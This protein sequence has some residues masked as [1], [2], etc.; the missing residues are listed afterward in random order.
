MPVASSTT[1]V[2]TATKSI[3]T[4][5]IKLAPLLG[6]FFRMALELT[7][8]KTRSATAPYTLLTLMCLAVLTVPVRGQNNSSAVRGLLTGY[9][10]VAY[11]ALPGDHFQNDFT[12]NFAPTLLFQVH[13]DILFDGEMDFELE[14]GGTEVHLEHAQI[15]Y[16]GFEHLQFS[17][18][19]FHLPF[20]TW[21][22]ASWIN[23]MPTPPL[24]YEDS[25]GAPPENALLPLPFD[26]GVTARVTLPLIDGWR[27]SAALWVSQ[28]PASGVPSH[29]HGEE[30]P[31][32][33]PASDAPP[34]SY[35]ANFEDNN[36]DKMV[37]LRLRAVSGGGL[38]LQGSGFR[39]AYDEAGD[40]SVYGLNLSLIWTPGSVPQPLFEF[41]AE[42]I[43]LKQEYQGQDAV[44][45]VEYGGY[46]VQLS[47][48]LD[49]FEPVARWSHLPR[50]LA[51]EGPVVERQRQLAVGLNY[52]I[53]PSVPVKAAYHFELNGTDGFY[54]QWVVGF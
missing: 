52:W 14:G 30:G 20:G 22:H 23:R 7:L 24:L 32:D 5:P 21:M 35:G 13:D 47:R 27:T 44:E 6:R 48:R 53:F 31:D 40:L 29:A 10:S 18:G 8:E 4:P 33:E 37:G 17:A 54:L 46:Y 19:M 41:R 43:V 2:R 39:A 16:L 9:G 42:G 3:G 49:A 38:T 34:L 50:A 1:R 26:V 36:S 51:G 25:H 11:S 45:S 28:G 12:T 15:H